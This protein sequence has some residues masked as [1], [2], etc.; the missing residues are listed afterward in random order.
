MAFTKNNI[1]EN[2]MPKKL[3]K[4][5]FFITTVVVFYLAVVPGDMIAIDTNLGDKFNH[6]L[7]FFTLS[8]LLNRSSSSYHARVR[9]M[10]SLLFFGILIEFVQHYLPHRESS[11]LD[12]LADLV[13]ILSFQFLL[14]SYRWYT[15][16]D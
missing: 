7:A 9:N 4:T 11:I 12:I 3:Y 16:Y 6:F 5:I 2:L 8:L 13:G 1:K 15:K 10:L 14:S